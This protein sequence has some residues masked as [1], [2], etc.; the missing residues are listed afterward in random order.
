MRL[1]GWKIPVDHLSASSLA[2]A[3]TCWEQFRVEKILGHKG[4]VG[5]S[6]FVGRVH[7]RSAEQLLRAKLGRITTPTGGDIT[8]AFGDAWTESMEEEEPEWE[9][10][11][12]QVIE[13]GMK[14]LGSLVDTSFP[15]LMPLWVEERFEETIPGVPVP[16][17]GFIDCWEAERIVEFKTAK[18]KVSKAKGKWRAQAMI[19]QLV[20]HRPMEWI[21]TTR[22][23]TPVTYEPVLGFPGLRLEPGNPDVTVT[24]V[25]QTIEVMNDLYA[26]YGPDKPWPLN[27]LLHQYACDY[28]FAGPKNVNPICPA[29][30]SDDPSALAR[31]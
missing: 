27:G 23:V 18:Q 20:T 1:S 31:T 21:V 9:I 2:T 3:M 26:R 17:T 13:T 15:N 16:I 4:K 12:P 19:Y 10:P 29:W 24:L 6:G 11:P 22:Q 14:M 30:R 25:M 28:C 8:E 7:H 5:L